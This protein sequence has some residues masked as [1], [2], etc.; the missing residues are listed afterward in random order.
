A[1]AP[2]SRLGPYEIDSPLGAGGMGEVYRAKDTRLDRSVAIKVLPGNVSKNPEMKERFEREARAVSSLNH[3]NICTLYD[4]GV[5]DGTAYLVMELIEGETLAARL[6]KGALPTEEVLRYATQVADALDRA[7]RSGIVHRDLK[8]GNIMITKP[9]AKL[10]D[11]G[12]ARTVGLGGAPGSQSLSPT[13]SHPLTAEGTILGTF[14]YMA[15]EQLEG[16]EAD[17]RSDIFAFGAV[18][19]EM[20]T[21]KR[22]FDARSQALLI[23]AIM[24]TDPP[25]LS[26]AAP[27]AP[28]AF[29]RVVRQCLAKDPDDRW[30][31]AGDLKRELAWIA[32]AGSQAGVPAPVV[33]QRKKS[34]RT[35][36][37]VAAVA[38]VALAGVLPFAIATWR[39][40][41]EPLPV[42]R[43]SVTAPEKRVLGSGFA[44]SPDGRLLALTAIA[45]GRASLWLRPLDA[46]EPKPLAETEGATL[47]FWSPDGRRL[48]F[49][50][51]GKLR[52]ADVGTG[53]VQAVCDVTE[54]RGASWTRDG[55]ILLAQSTTSP[56]VVVSENGGAPTPVTRL[57]G[58]SGENS[59][60]WPQILPDGKHFLFLSR[61]SQRENGRILVGSLDGG[62]PVELLRGVSSVQYVSPGYLFYIR[63]RALIAQPFDADRRQVTGEPR[64]LASEAIA[65]GE[66]GPT[67]YG[68]FSV[69]A[70]GV[71]A[72]QVGAGAQRQIQWF[73]RTGM[74]LGDVGPIGFYD[75]PSL[76]LDGARVAVT[77]TESTGA[78][79]DIWLLEMARGV[80]TRLTFN[81]A[82][83]ISPVLSP[84][85][86]R[87]AYSSNR[88]GHWDMYWRLASGAGEEQLL[89]PTETGVFADDWSR[90]GR[91]ILYERTDPNTDS[92]L[93]IV[94]VGGDR[95]SRPFLTSPSTEVQG[96]FSPDAKFVSYTSIDSGHPEVF[97]QTLPPSGGKWQISN[98]G[99]SWS[100]WRADGKE[101]YYAEP[102]L[103]LMAVSVDTSSG[104]T[105]GIPR[106]LF[107]LPLPN[108]GFG[109]SRTQ[110]GVT[111][112]GQKFLV[113]ASAT[114]LKPST[115]TVVL[116]WDSELKPR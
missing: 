92:D 36:W 46:V 43:F 66:E 71:L 45:G 57:G 88:S 64:V 18:L 47:P 30:Q 13:M 28:P 89:V 48:G 74:K 27:M 42:Y 53:S 109:N 40:T 16:K 5:E 6:A 1:I 49:F 9:G 91:L 69:G 44:L 10:L 96:Q 84:R 78:T 76:A 52:W 82:A 97:V 3:P 75:D 67:G 81:P 99:G 72:Y 22:A 14:Q 24:T 33:A 106:R 35:S 23:S 115:I 107:T 11:F 80:F 86:D 60:R 54:G 19:Y 50:A 8:P 116:N 108:V 94:D 93:W 32:N 12:L 2:G 83:D 55:R 90:D 79:S 110:Y 77:R 102:D 104:F 65:Y 17:A 114:D 59:H 111:A 20:V 21:G 31:S 29:E 113:N 51:A 95:K 61:G 39:R 7:H 87:V 62:E 25:P 58:A 4:V 85:A 26:I 68:A 98:A 73:D 105:A 34:A 15:P 41:A 112:D 56:I 103:G 38:V 63:E 100:S 101:I 70:Q 37:A